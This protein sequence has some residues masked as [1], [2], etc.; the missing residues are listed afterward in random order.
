MQIQH[1]ESL[2]AK[3]KKVNSDSEEFY[4]L[5]KLTTPAAAPIQVLV[6][7]EGQQLTMEVDT[8]AAVSVISEATRRK[9]FPKLRPRKKSIVLKTYTDETL[10]TLGELNVIVSYKHQSVELPLII[11]AGNGPNLLGRNWLQHIQLDCMAKH[12]HNSN[13]TTRATF[14]AL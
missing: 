2:C 7:I 11:V 13:S 4:A 14:P 5:H 3:E 8:R 10:K 12:S 6:E 1:Q 9:I